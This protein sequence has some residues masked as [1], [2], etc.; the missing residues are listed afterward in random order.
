MP[1]KAEQSD[2]Y[3]AVYGRNAD[4]PTPVLAAAT[5][6]DCYDVAIE[7][8]RIA[9]KY[10]TPVFV[11]TDSYLANAA[12][13]W[14]LPDP[15]ALPDL[16]VKFLSDGYGSS[17]LQHR[18]PA[19]LARPWVKP[20]TPGLE[21][22]AG[23]LEKDFTTGHIS[24]EPDN[25]QYMTDTRAAKIA[26]IA[27]DIPLQ[28]VALG[29]D[30]GPLALVGWG[31]TFGPIRQAVRRARD[32]GL[33]ISHIHVRYLN[34][35]PANLGELLKGFDKILV[36]EMNTGQLVTMLRSSYLVPA[37]RLPK[38]TGQPFKIAEILNASMAVLEK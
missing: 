18:N 38:V 14:R 9:T 2:L 7:A 33:D 6:S 1:T 17:D 32:K 20:G 22:R 21:Y 10:M 15:R 27:A 8:V 29:P 3:Q 11:L 24:Y 26:G 35:F 16:K 4:S 30:S 28:E 19:T 25:H 34:P 13:P 5:P 36:P 23:G 31:S 12:E 37:E